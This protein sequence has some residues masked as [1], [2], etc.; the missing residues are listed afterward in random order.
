[1]HLSAK[2]RSVIPLVRFKKILN[3]ILKFERIY[4]TCTIIKEVPLIFKPCLYSNKLNQSES[5]G[6]QSFDHIQILELSA[7]DQIV[8]DAF[9]LISDLNVRMFTKRS[10]LIN[11]QVF[12]PRHPF[13]RLHP[14]F[15]RQEK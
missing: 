7:L 8:N 12:I 13:L 5:S 14:E 2:A 3:K 15:F 9:W 4:G 6:A 1:M 11:F 10:I